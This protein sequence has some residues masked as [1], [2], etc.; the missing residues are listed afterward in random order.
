M[1]RVSVESVQNVQVRI[2]A[3]DHS[4][5]ADEPIGVGD[6]FGPGPFD[7]LLSALGSCMTM[8]L[9]L[10]ARRKKWHLNGSR[11]IFSMTVFMPMTL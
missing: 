11:S 2:E 9:L 4:W 3:G 10:Y 7:L 8:T 5:F 1:A 6:G